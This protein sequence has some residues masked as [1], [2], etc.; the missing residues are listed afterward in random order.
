MLGSLVAQG[1]MDLWPVLLL[2]TGAAILG[3]HVGY[4]I[5]R[6]GGRRAV[7]AIAHRSGGGRVM[8]RAEAFIVRWGAPGIFFSR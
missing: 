5:G 7:D 6:L 2:A 4:I 8:H 1:D 3:D